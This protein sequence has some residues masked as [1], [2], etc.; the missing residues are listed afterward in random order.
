M[1]SSVEGQL[2]ATVSPWLL[3]GEG[4]LEAC[5]TLEVEVSFSAKVMAILDEEFAA[6]L[7]ALSGGAGE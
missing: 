2:L 1:F 6:C 7:P 5:L 3:A 4:S